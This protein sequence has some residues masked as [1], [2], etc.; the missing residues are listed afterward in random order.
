MFKHILV[1]TDGSELSEKAVVHA[2]ELARINGAELM[3]FTAVPR[4][5]LSYMEAT[6]LQGTAESERI[7]GERLQWAQRL[8]DT[9][10]DRARAQQVACKGVVMHSS[11]VA[12]SIIE[13]A[14]AHGCDLIVMASHGRRGLGRMLL[15]SETLHVLTH[16]SLPVLVLR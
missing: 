14:K 5:A 9:V 3:A 7:D 2:I 16:S 6:A 15:G 13:A 8:L 1:A 10:A 12:E 4:Y 11:L